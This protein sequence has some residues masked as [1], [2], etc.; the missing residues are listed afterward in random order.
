MREKGKN[1]VVEF[2]IEAEGDEYIFPKKSAAGR[3]SSDRKMDV[4]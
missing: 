4:D 1:F 2:K 3:W